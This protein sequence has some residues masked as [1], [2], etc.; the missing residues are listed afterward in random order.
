MIKNDDFVHHFFAFQY[1]NTQKTKVFVLECK[2]LLT[3][4]IIVIYFS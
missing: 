2:N 3:L 4:F 1:K